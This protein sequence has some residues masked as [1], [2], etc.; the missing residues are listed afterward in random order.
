M[1]DLENAYASAINRLTD[2]DEER[3]FQALL[4]STGG[5]APIPSESPGVIQKFLQG[6]TKGMRATPNIFRPAAQGEDIA[7]RVGEAAALPFTI[8]FNGIM[9]GLE[10]SGLISFNARKKIE[11]AVTELTV[12]GAPA[13]MGPR[14]P[15]IKTAEEPV[16]PA[17]VTSEPGVPGRPTIS[18][19]SGA[20]TEAPRVAEVAKPTPPVAPAEPL[21][22]PSGEIRVNL[23]RINATE[24]VKSTL[25][26]M[27]AMNAEKLAA[28]RAKV[29]HEQTI[30]GS[31]GVS[32]EE[33]LSLP[34]RTLT[35]PEEA[36]KLRDTHVATA[37]TLTD[38]AEK[39]K[40]G[41]TEAASQLVDAFATAGELDARLDVAK[42]NIARG[43]ESMS[44]QA[45]G[46]RAP[47]ALGEVANLAEKYRGME[48]ADP[49]ILAERLTAIK[50]KTQRMDWARQV[51]GY[52]KLGW[53]SFNELYV[54]TL[55]SPASHAANVVG[56]TLIASWAPVERAVSA[57]LRPLVGGDVTFAEAAGMLRAVPEG[58]LEGLRLFKDYLWE[59]SDMGK[60]DYARTPAII[61]ANYG[62]QDSFLAKPFDVMG[63]LIRVH[64]TLM[65]GALAIREAI[66]E[67]LSGQDFVDRVRYIEG[68]PEEFPV[69]MQDAN[70]FKLI[71]TF[72]DPMGPIGTGLQFLRDIFFPPAK[73]LVPFLHTPTRILYWAASRVPGVNLPFV[74]GG[75]IGK[76]L[77]AGGTPRQ[78]ALGKLASGAMATSAIA[79]LAMNG[80]VTGAG[81]KDRQLQE[82]KRNT[83]WQPYSLKVGDEYF[84]LN[85]LDPFA[86]QLGMV[87]D[88]VEIMGE[89]PEYE[90]N[91]LG[92]AMALAFANN[93]VNKTYM[94]NLS[95]TLDALRDPDTNAKRYITNFTKS[96]VPGVVR[97]TK[98]EIDPT[99][100]D[101]Q[102]LL[103]A[104]KSNIP[105]YSED[106]PP[107]RNLF[108]EPILVP[109]GWG[110]DWISPI[111][112][113]ADKNDP[114]AKELDR[115]QV[116]I[117]PAGRVVYGTKPP[118][119]RMQPPKE[120]EGVPLTPAEYDYL[121]R[122]AG[123][124]LK[125]DGRGMKDTL[126]SMI[127][128]GKYGYHELSDG[129]DGSKAMA[130]R[131]VVHE[132][133]SA[134]QK[135]L[136]SEDP[137]L[138]RLVEER[139]TARKTALMPPEQTAQ[140]ER[141]TTLTP[142]VGR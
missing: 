125:I 133:R 58:F 110:P 89:L 15:R 102:T 111:T 64:T 138:L 119:I 56:N 24:S 124:D 91:Q 134:A 41:D 26:T 142:I 13:L 108:G 60:A 40:A 8:P 42:R 115:L 49:A 122:L 71:Q 93:F 50:T 65:G 36:T 51:A 32:L 94:T 97:A 23:E 66:S 95:N 99:L 96:L 7:G 4:G 130:I 28:S 14:A 117:A 29:S 62:L 16:R 63:S 113:S 86:F 38:L 137:E 116:D 69:M 52:A 131:Q 34:E 106:L 21:P 105:G 135:Q 121:V 70:E 98:R 10:D 79:Y 30:A 59:P 139:I 57:A 75:S 19:E 53:D 72:Q 11:K 76:D 104:L 140:R 127:V 39:T 81:P 31:K 87:A 114:V 27:N 90:A 33:A 129:P 128:E 109:E 123:N 88:A 5:A 83:G 107:R 61:S 1:S 77:I 103:D 20:V 118:D 67:R 25:K 78:L 46:K 3:Q 55:L 43:L 2:E 35:L 74:V 12:G 45:E 85:R 68:H 132:Y 6:V 54:N 22:P 73:I 18:P 9:Q 44:I 100:R 136:L 141:A 84:G 47:F 37:E 17:G 112:Y 82:M 120:K 92:M 101:A 126:R 80:Y 48:G